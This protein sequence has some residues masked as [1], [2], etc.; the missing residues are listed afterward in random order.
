MKQI[1]IARRKFI[2]QSLK[3]TALVLG[4]SSLSPNIVSA[5]F[6]E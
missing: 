1:S 6:A 4:V 2:R 3:Q 5:A